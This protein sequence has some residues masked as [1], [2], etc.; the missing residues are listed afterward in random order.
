M[1]QE[2]L[3]MRKIE[4]IL[5]L[6]YQVRLSHRAIA[7]SC[8]VS[9]STVSEYVTH[10]KAAGIRWPLPEG[11]SDEQLEAL[12]FPDR[13]SVSGGRI[14][15]PDWKYIQK[16]LKRKGV[17][18]SLLW[19]EYRQEHADGYGYSQFCFRYRQWVNQLD[20]VMRQKHKA[21]EKLF[22]D[23]AGQTVKVVNPQTGEIREAQVFVA[24]LGA[25]NYTYAE[26]HWQQDLPNWIGAHVRALEFLGGVPELLVPDNLKAGVTSPNLY[27]P[28]LNMTYLDLAC[29]YGIA[30][31][32]A[33]VKTP[34]DKATVEV[35]VQVVERW[36]LA[37]LRDRH[38]FS[39]FELN[40]AILKLLFELNR[41][42]MKH[43]G[44]SRL[45]I[46]EALDKPALAPL[47]E[48]PYEFALWKRARVH[49]D[50]H[51]CFEKHYY[52]V[53]YTLIGKQVDIRAT[54]NTVEIFYQR[55]RVA[56]HRRSE[57][58]GRYSTLNEHMP[59]AHTYYS[60]WSPERFLRW[61]EEIGEQTTELISR[62]L[63]SRRHPQQAYRTCLGVLGL[64]KCYP[65][66]RLEAACS[67]AN[68]AGIC[69]YK[70]VLN[71]LKNK[72]DQCEL[73]P[74]AFEPLPPHTNIRG[75]N[76]YH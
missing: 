55:Q 34:R 67:R 46:F 28:D 10:A 39:L 2:S 11:I 57:V 66:L 48:K 42:E 27:E 9:T 37:R 64:A 21:G 61:A 16:E 43:L 14:P 36:I 22:V 19:V 20:P 73:N 76:Y 50:Y 8:A 30:V 1:A 38:F 33:R 5:R 65:S 26:A 53:P 49:I 70:G 59:P 17:T 12:L 41:R 52:S 29:H 4:E 72:L 54:E 6:K 40:Q 60:Q 31:V 58:K 3:S 45:E 15:Q 18:L 35:G 7:K 75:E 51:I 23:Y 25:S 32:P 74:A 63:D 62:V 47:P 68:I 44:Q 24:T 13:G 69:S 71:I 56:S